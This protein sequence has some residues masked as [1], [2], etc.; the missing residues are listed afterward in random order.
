MGDAAALAG[1]A[2]RQSS[3]AADEGCVSAAAA[4]EAC[5][6]AAGPGKQGVLSGSFAYAVSTSP[7]S[8][9]ELASANNRYTAASK[10]HRP[11]CFGMPPSSSVH[12]FHFKGLA[13]CH[14]LAREAKD[15]IC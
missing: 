11:L 15:M 8:P 5:V 4:D 3:S 13:G 14:V 6:S 9:T 1:M 2:L 12:S 10:G 7:L